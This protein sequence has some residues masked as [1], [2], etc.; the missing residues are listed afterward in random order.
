MFVLGFVWYLGHVDFSTTRDVGICYGVW[1]PAC[2]GVYSLITRMEYRIPL[3]HRQVD[4]AIGLGEL[5]ISVD[6]PSRRAIAWSVVS[7]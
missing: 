2:T 5:K 6:I 3:H 4:R 1:R 7:W